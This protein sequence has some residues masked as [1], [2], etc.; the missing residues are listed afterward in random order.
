MKVSQW[1]GVVLITFVISFTLGYLTADQASPGSSIGLG[2]KCIPFVKESLT[3]M[4]GTA[5]VQNKPSELVSPNL[6]DNSPRAMHDIIAEIDELLFQ[7]E[8]N[9]KQTSLAIKLYALIETLTVDELIALGTSL[10]GKNESQ[11]KTLSHMIIGL[12]TEKSPEKALAFALRYNP[13]P[14]SPYFIT[15]LK[16]QIAE[17]NPELGFE[18]LNQILDLPIEDI[19]LSEHSQLIQTLA[20]GDLKRLVGTLV[21]FKDLGIKLDNSLS[22]FTYG[23]KTSGEHL[24]LFNELRQLNDMSILGSVLINWMKIS[25]TDVFDRLNEIS[26]MAER[27]KLTDSAFHYW[28]YDKPEVAADHHLANASN[29]VKMLKK[30]MRIWPD[31]KAADALTWISGQSDI[32][33]NRYKID[34]LK[35]LSRTDPEFV[36]SQLHDINLN[37]SENID[38]Y[39]KLYS[40]FKLKSSADAEQFVNALPFKDEVLGNTTENTAPTDSYITKINKAFRRYFDFKY[41]KTFALAIGDNGAYA[42]SYVVNKA[43]QSEANQLAISRCDQ[44]RYKN[45]IANKCRIYAEG[46][47]KLFN[48]TE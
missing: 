5:D 46:D 23:L 30:I 1:I 13:M 34:Y 42:Y 9:P 6:I 29:K 21:K 3:N 36:E 35:G 47:V 2:S 27:I 10:S 41:D 15:A 12:L 14:D 16:A 38:F 22:G 43:S 37:N 32:D 19:N 18:Y 45:N 4:T 20:N 17:K 28:M 26:D 40:G 31:K 8:E 11:R 39:K 24:N 7:L 25:P 48:L 33:T 44:R